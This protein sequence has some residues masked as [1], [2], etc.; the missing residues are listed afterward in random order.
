MTIYK[1]IKIQ[2]N[3]V[4]LLWILGQKAQV[5]SLTWPNTLRK[6]TSDENGQF[7]GGMLID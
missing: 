3:V 2:I 4:E 5:I 6:N 7:Y 1:I